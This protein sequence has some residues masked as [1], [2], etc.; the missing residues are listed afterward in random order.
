M[1][2]EYMGLLGQAP[3]VVAA[4][5][6]VTE[7]TV[8]SGLS[9]GQSLGVAPAEFEK[10]WASLSEWDNAITLLK[11]DGHEFEIVGPVHTGRF[12][13]DKRRFDLNPVGWG[14]AGHIAPSNIGAIFAVSLPTRSDAKAQG[15]LFLNNGGEMSFAVMVPVVGGRS[16]QTIAKQFNETWQLMRTLV[17]VCEG[18]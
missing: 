1:Q 5:L 4:K 8:L 15:V 16:S 18:R 3:A 12:G 6:G 11:R 10:V 2:Q 13:R 14:A 9:F 7:G 17:E